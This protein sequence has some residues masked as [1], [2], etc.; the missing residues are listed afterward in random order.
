MKVFDDPEKQAE[1]ERHLQFAGE[2][3]E[4]EQLNVIHFP[5]IPQ[6][7]FSW[8]PCECCYNKLGGSR[9]EVKGIGEKGWYLYLVCTECFDALD[10]LQR[11]GAI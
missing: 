3:I 7:L 4:S 6:E 10:I 5:D 1:F 2:F 9:Y 11:E 8:E